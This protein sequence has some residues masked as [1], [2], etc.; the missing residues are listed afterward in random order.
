MSITRKRLC[1]GSFSTTLSPIYTAPSTGGS[2]TLATGLWLCNKT[3][4]DVKISIKISDVEII[5][6]YTLEDNESLAISLKDANI[7]IEAGEKIEGRCSVLNAVT[8]YLSGV[9]V[10]S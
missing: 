9:E 5:Y 4:D 7:L 6:D 10:K 2:Y 1:K 3:S 8:Y